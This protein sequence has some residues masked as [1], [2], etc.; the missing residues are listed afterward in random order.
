MN[1]KMIKKILKLRMKELKIIII[2]YNTF[3]L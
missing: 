2:N 1:D 3:F